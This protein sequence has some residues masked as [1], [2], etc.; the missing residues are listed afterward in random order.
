MSTDDELL[1]R[2]TTNPSIMGGKPVV[3][4][5]RITIEQIVRWFAARTSEQEL[6]AEFPFLEAD[7]IRA[8]L[9]YASRVTAL[10]CMSGEAVAKATHLE[11]APAR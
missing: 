9:L 6:L 1:R 3:R 7:D 10:T 8:A 5:L 4:G 2:I 11:D